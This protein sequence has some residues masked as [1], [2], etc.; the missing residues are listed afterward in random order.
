MTFKDEWDAEK[1]AFGSLVES[2]AY[3]AWDEEVPEPI[4]EDPEPEPVSDSDVIFE[5][6]KP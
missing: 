1:E 2:I 3:G 5:P 6:E 4:E